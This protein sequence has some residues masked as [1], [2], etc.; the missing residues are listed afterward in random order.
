MI[1]VFMRVFL[2]FLW[3]PCMVCH[4]DTTWCPQLLL[5]TSTSSTFLRTHS[6]FLLHGRPVPKL[7]TWVVQLLAKLGRNCLVPKLPAWVVTLLE[8]LAW[9]FKAFAPEDGFNFRCSV[10]SM[11]TQIST[12]FSPF[13]APCDG[14]TTGD[15]TR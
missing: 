7:P 14:N 6:F 5:W 4:K 3:F 15:S 2:V 1:I 8:P 13:E 10:C 9:W 11:G 12:F